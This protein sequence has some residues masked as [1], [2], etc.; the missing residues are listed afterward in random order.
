MATDPLFTEADNFLRVLG[1]QIA[2]LSA[3]SRILEDDKTEIRFSEYRKFRDSMSGCL[4]FTI[5]IQNR[6]DRIAE[7]DPKTA[8]PLA[9]R[10]DGL[11][12]KIWGILLKGALHFFQVIS[13]KNS[14]PI[15]THDVFTHELRT[16]HDAGKFF[17]IPRYARH[18]S[19]AMKRDYGVAEKILLQI[20]ERAPGMLNIA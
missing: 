14:L 5:I 10:L 4:T 6:I 7:T 17:Q 19:D 15:G 12:V 8:E 11:T 3:H 20:I 1:E 2:E 13:Q 16:L 9:E 18:A